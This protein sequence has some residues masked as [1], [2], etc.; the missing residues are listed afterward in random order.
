[1]SLLNSD[2]D[3]AT[4]IIS[5]VF[6][7]FSRT[8]LST[9]LSGTWISALKKTVLG[10]HGTYILVGDTGS[11]HR[12][13]KRRVRECQG[14]GGGELRVLLFKCRLVKGGT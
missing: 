6:L 10:S 7:S 4:Y 1:M 12:R 11:A 5:L 8:F 9:Y 13:G 3:W 2:G 14:V